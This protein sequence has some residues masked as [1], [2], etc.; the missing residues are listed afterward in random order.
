M[1]QNVEN[2]PVCSHEEASK[3]KCKTVFEIANVG[4]KSLINLT[5]SEIYQIFLLLNKTHMPS[6]NYWQIN[7]RMLHYILRDGLG[8]CICMVSSEMFRF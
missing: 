5:S 2:P 7:I 8:N 6:K 1:H 3:A 4:E